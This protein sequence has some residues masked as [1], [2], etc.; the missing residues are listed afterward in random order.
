MDNEMKLKQSQLVYRMFCNALDGNDWKYR[1]DDENLRIECGAQGDDLPMELSANFDVDKQLM[2]I[3]SHLPFVIAED[4]RIDIAV[5]I[6]VINNMM[7]DGCF[8]YDVGTGHIFFRVTNS[9]WDSVMS[10]D[11]C[12]ELLYKACQTIDEYNDKL[13]MIAKGMISIEQFL[14]SVNN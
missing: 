2:M 1:K 3:L 4:K 5:A 11:V 6:S 13:L 14:Q 8:D 7:V 10:E 12:L 9:Y